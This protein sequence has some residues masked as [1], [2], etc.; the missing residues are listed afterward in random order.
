MHTLIKPLYISGQNPIDLE[1]TP[2][3]VRSI[4]AILAGVEK[5]T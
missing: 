3:K 2:P 1:M 5:S 4:V